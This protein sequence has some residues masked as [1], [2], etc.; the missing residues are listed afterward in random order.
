MSWEEAGIFRLMFAFPEADFAFLFVIDLYAKSSRRSV[1]LD[2][3]K[4]QLETRSNLN[5][6]L[7]FNEKLRIGISYARGGVRELR[8]DSQV[9]RK[10]CSKF[11]NHK[12]ALVPRVNQK[13]SPS[14]VPVVT[15]ASPHGSNH[16]VL[17]QLP[18]LLQKRI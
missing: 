18:R 17:H 10:S 9:S 4:T 13:A 12:A 16:L 3:I 11:L 2:E 1:P 15:H 7:K 6:L 5:S 14:K 8:L